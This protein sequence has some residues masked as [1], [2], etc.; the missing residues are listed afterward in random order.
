MRGMIAAVVLLTALGWGAVGPSL[1]VFHM[2]NALPTGDQRPESHA[3]ALVM[4]LPAREAGFPCPPIRTEG[5]PGRDFPEY[6]TCAEP[7]HPAP[8]RCP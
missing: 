5:A 6:L 1:A 4:V 2:P 7:P 3:Q 8:A